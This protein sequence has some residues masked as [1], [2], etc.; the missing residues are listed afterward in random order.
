MAAF[1][2]KSDDVFLPALREDLKI[3]QGGVLRNGS[4]SWL[5]QDPLRNRYF[6]IAL[7]NFELLNLWRVMEVKQ[8]IDYASHKLRR[9]VKQAEIDEL[10]KFLLGNGLCLEAT[11]GDYNAFYQQESASNRG[12]MSLIIHNYLFFKIPLVRPQGFL[13]AIWPLVGCLFTRLSAWGFFAGALLAFYLV[14]RQ[15]EIFAGTFLSFFSLE[16]AILYGVSLILLKTLHELGH[17]FMAKKYNVN[18]ATI[19]IA[20]M[21][22]L[23]VLYTDTSSAARLKN[24]KQR[25]MIDFAGIFT[26]LAVAV[27][28]T[29]LWVF[30]PDGPLRSICFTTATLSWVLSLLVNLNPFMRF[31]GYY[32][33]CDLLGVE[34]LQ[35]RG[36]AMAKWRMREIL[37]TPDREPPETT[38]P[39]LRWLMVLHAWGT[40]IYR[41]FLFLG[42]AILVYHFF[43]KVVGIFLFIV[44]ILWFILFPV[45]RELK[46]WWSARSEFFVNRRSL[47]S[48]G[49]II[50][51]LLAFCVPWSSSITIPSIVKAGNEIRL[52]PP[53][54]GYLVYSALEDDKVIT[55]DAVLA[56]LSSA[57]LEAEI[58]VSRRR[59][60]LLKVRLA[61]SVAD[62]EELSIST[63]L[64]KELQTETDKLNTLL[65]K[66]Q[67]FIIKAPFEGQI[68]DVDANLHT[69]QWVANDRHL[70]VLRST[71][72]V[73]ISGLSQGDDFVRMKAD[74]VGIFIPDNVQ[75]SSFPV[76]VIQMASMAQ[77]TLDDEIL[78]DI[79]G[80]RIPLIANQQDGMKPL[81]TW[82][83]VTFE[84]EDLPDNFE[85]KSLMRGVVVIEGVRESYF[86]KFS[87]RVLSVLIRESG[88]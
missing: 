41:F 84:A 17:A 40:W 7:E 53:E 55:T 83:R 2:P 66:R 69:Q 71:D 39:G 23:P 35:E 42:I 86:T 31:D 80:G 37:F 56:K 4:P 27:I 64:G 33:L 78:S 85:L 70:A 51:L 24:H 5:I 81:G 75:I 54:A 28:A 12:W 10:C 13:D 16:G 60:A 25:L 67:A 30:L 47:I 77:E 26:E 79:H 19:G 73:R 21:V 88:F 46:I 11:G 1:Q 87:R 32:I 34:N 14:S 20:F 76:R 8:F 44:E 50:A 68:V 61:R 3:E 15:W 58:E 57:K 22:L 45:W 74:E 49:F 65:E 29:L 18:V 82:F 48:C 52:F 59:Q 43:I 63:V 9:L 62:R 36:F 6:R 72:G 38:E